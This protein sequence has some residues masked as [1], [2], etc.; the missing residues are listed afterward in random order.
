[1]IRQLNRQIGRRS[2]ERIALTRNKLATLEKVEIADSGDAV[3]PEE[4]VKCLFVL[5]FLGSQRDYS[6]TEL[7]EELVQ[8]PAE[9]IG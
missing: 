2:Y 1:M 9:S 8:H 5:E 4:A 3:T 6:E 7:E